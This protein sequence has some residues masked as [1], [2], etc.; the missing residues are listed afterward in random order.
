[1]K[2]VLI[3]WKVFLFDWMNRF[4]R[5]SFIILFS[6]KTKILSNVFFLF[7]F[8]LKNK[9]TVISD[10]TLLT[11]GCGCHSDDPVDIENMM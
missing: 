5:S 2:K 6:Q 4:I 1:M 8:T 7:R 10:L 9:D 11:A 3:I